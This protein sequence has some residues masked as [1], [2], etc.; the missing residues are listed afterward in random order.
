MNEKPNVDVVAVMGQ[1]KWLGGKDPDPMTGWYWSLYLYAGEIIALK[2]LTSTKAV[3]S[4]LVLDESELPAYCEDPVGAAD[5]IHG[6]CVEC[7][8]RGW[9]SY[10][11]QDG[12]VGDDEGSNETCHLCGDKRRN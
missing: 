6:R 11:E 9:A 10:D 5:L 8:G 7:H 12:L 2:M 1:G 4:K 3:Y